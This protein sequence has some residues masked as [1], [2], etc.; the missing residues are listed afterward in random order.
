VQFSRQFYPARGN[1]AHDGIRLAPA[2]PEKYAQFITKLHEGL[3][4]LSDFVSWRT[5]RQT[6]G[7]AA[8][9]SVQSPDLGIHELFAPERNCHDL[10]N[11]TF[12]SNAGATT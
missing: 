8:S 5:M 7:K 6:P 10:T 1:T 9:F 11:S 12:R 2:C 3:P 4:I